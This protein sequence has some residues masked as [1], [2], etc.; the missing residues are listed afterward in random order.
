[1]IFYKKITLATGFV[2][3]MCLSLLFAESGDKRGDVLK[4]GLENEIVE[5]VNELERRDDRSY[6]DELVR[7]FESTR[8]GAVRDSIL[9]FYGAQKN[10]AFKDYCLLVLEDPYAF[11]NTTVSSVFQYVQKIP[12]REAAPLVRDLLSNESGEFRD[13]AI[14]TLGKI[15][16]E[17][18]ALYL[19]EY[20]QSNIPGDE[21]QR[22]IIRQNI[23]TALG[24]LKSESVWEDFI[25]VAQDEEENTMI[26][27]TA[28]R[29][30]GMI[31]KEGGVPILA[32]LFEAEDPIL[33]A[34]VVSALSGYTDQEAVEVVLEGLKDAH[35][36]VRL[37]ALDAIKKQGAKKAAPIVRYRAENDP[38]EAVKMKSYDVLAFLDEHDTTGW[39]IEQVRDI[40]TS[41]KV[42]LRIITV[43]MEHNRSAVIEDAVQVAFASLKDDKKKWIRYELGKLFA[44]YDDGA[45]SAVAEAYITHGDTLTKGIGIELYN[46]NR[47]S[48]LKSHVEAI[49]GNKKMG[50]LQNQAKRALS[51]E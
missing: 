39:M 19:F 20:L 24:E 47:F 8:S 9:S 50:G 46:K 51:S 27:A 14:R 23:M 12:L 33:R 28:A 4:Y 42:R 40:K 38:V 21:R 35:Y 43:L 18:D 29:A 3:L 37:E 5:L 16:N 1:M 22:L 49:A 11:R 10:P 15:G 34:A 13:Q 17:E 32:D 41:D 26:R 2:I 36:R 45:L 48:N 25:L 6:N 30:I 44:K 31:G 7:L